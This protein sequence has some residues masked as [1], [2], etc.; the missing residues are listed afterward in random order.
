MFNVYISKDVWKCVDRN[1][2]IAK[3]INVILSKLID[4]ATVLSHFFVSEAFKKI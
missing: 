2:N 4:I 3:T 1:N